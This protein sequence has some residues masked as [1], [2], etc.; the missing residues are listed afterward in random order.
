MLKI[1]LAFMVS[2]VQYP[3]ELDGLD[4]WIVKKII[5]YKSDF[6]LPVLKFKVSS[7]VHEQRYLQ[8]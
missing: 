2:L 6:V 8:Q 5:E 1:V 4:D 7:L 3:S